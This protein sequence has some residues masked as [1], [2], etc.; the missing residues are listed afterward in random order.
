MMLLSSFLCGF[1]EQSGCG[2][3]MDFLRNILGFDRLFYKWA[4]G[5]IHY[6]CG[7]LPCGYSTSA[8]NLDNQKEE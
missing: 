4:F 2:L 6:D 8:L 7:R 5:V 3:F 1:V